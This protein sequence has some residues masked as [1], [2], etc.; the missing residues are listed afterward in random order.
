M[1]ASQGLGQNDRYGIS[2]GQGDHVDRF[3]QFA[4][5]MINLTVAVAILIKQS[6][7]PGW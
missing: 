5:Y 4:Q 6:P 3:R 1:L 2:S 7:I